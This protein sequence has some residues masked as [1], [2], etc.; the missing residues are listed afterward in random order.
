[1]A[2]DLI[3]TTY[4]TPAG[5]FCGILP[6]T[7]ACLTC[8]CPDCGGFGRAGVPIAH[9]ITCYDEHF[10]PEQRTSA[11]AEAKTYPKPVQEAALA[12]AFHRIAAELAA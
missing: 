12:A 2:R 1:M 5:C 9:S 11:V 10:T 6:S 7:G 8:T 4:P 3:G